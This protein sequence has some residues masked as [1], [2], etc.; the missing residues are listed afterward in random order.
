MPP[1]PAPCHQE[2]YSLLCI[3]F[4]ETI[5]NVILCR[6]LYISLKS[7]NKCGHYWYRVIYVWNRPLRTPI[8]TKL[9][10]RWW[11]FMDISFVELH[12]NW[13]ENVENAGEI[14]FTPLGKVRSTQRNRVEMIYNEFYPNQRRN[15]DVTSRN[16]FTPPLSEVWFSLTQFSTNRR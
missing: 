12:R 14:L 2:N 3:S 7:D 5:L 15:V 11:S 13:I 16:S 1:T 6:F 9:T 4:H 8:S 10:S